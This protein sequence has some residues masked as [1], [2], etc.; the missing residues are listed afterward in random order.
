M[1]L[2]YFLILIGLI[3]LA[4]STRLFLRLRSLPSWRLFFTT[5]TLFLLSG[6]LLGPHGINLISRTMLLEL[7]P[8]TVLLM[9]WVGIV[10]GL[11]L[12]WHHLRRIPLRIAAGSQ[13]QAVVSLLI[14]LGGFLLLWRMWPVLTV[15]FDSP[16]LFAMLAVIG[17]STAPEVIQ[18]SGLALIRN[19]HSFRTA[20]F[21]ANLGRITAIFAI[22]I[23]Y[24]LYRPSTG[25]LPLPAVHWIMLTLVLGAALGLVATF[26]CQHSKDE[27]GFLSSMTG[28]IIF[29]AGLAYYLHLSPLLLTLLM[30]IVTA[31][32]TPRAIRLFEV[33]SR[34][35]Q[36]VFL[37]LLILAGALLDIPVPGLVPLLLIYLVLRLLGKY[38]GNRLANVLLPQ[39]HR[40]S[41]RFLLPQG[42]LT[43]ALAIN[44]L[45]IYADTTA[46]AVFQILLLGSLCFS[47]LSLLLLG[48]WRR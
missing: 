20:L 39:H 15:P 36:A 38:A 11:Q 48:G 37:L 29:A 27:A 33:L 28:M 41:T 34:Y 35:D 43:L 5:S 14:I 4:G 9:G 21:F 25:L 32:S 2:T 40:S 24:A 23:L 45:Q 7:K 44:Q 16:R 6:I 1:K 8:V 22:G 42:A 31:N 3:S 12:R 17:L 13:I 47:F 26:F 30:G 19:Q 18:I 10:L 46:A